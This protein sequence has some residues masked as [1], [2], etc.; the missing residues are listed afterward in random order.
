MARQP[1]QPADPYYE[2]MKDDAPFKTRQRQID[3]VNW[4]GS[5]LPCTPKH[6]TESE[7]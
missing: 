2:T 6:E 5:G 4:A 1:N 3:E 7:G